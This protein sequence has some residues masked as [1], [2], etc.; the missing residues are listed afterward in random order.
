M[1]LTLCSQNV[2]TYPVFTKR[3]RPK[4]D[5]GDTETGTAEV[6]VLTL[7]VVRNGFHVS[8]PVLSVQYRKT[9]CYATEYVVQCRKYSTV[10]TAKPC[11]T[12]QSALSEKLLPTWVSV[13]E[14]PHVLV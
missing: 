11:S 7:P 3:K 13:L 14:L 4:S 9:E 5:V 12:A 2:T 6:T 10:N 1:K 8:W